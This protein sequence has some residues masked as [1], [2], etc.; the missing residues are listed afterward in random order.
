MNESYKNKNV[1]RFFQVII[2]NEIVC[3]Y[4]MAH[5]EY[6]RKTNV[7]LFLFLF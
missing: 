7:T 3:N 2:L 6:L 1:F 4:K 5:N